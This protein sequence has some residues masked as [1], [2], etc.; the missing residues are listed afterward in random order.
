M[1]INY[2]TC[3]YDL[4]SLFHEIYLGFSKVFNY[5]NEDL[6]SCVHES[7]VFTLNHFVVNKLTKHIL[8]CKKNQFHV[9]M[10]LVS[11]L[12]EICLFT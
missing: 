12:H 4:F 2:I 9:N 10:K 7:I 1:Y 5:I 8:A 3:K 11:C 6:V